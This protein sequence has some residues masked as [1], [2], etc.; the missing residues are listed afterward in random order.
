MFSRR[1][2]VEPCTSDNAGRKPEKPK[3]AARV[4]AAP[5]D[6]VLE[7]QRRLVAAAGL[8]YAQ[9]QIAEAQGM[10]EAD[11]LRQLYDDDD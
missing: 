3:K 5:V 2:G 7:E 9:R 6:E 11:M 1:F 8:S 10:S 4:E